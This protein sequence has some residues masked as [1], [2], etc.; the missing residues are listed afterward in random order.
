MPRQK[1][2]SGC[3]IA[4]TTPSDAVAVATSPVPS[5]PTDWWCRLLTRQLPAASTGDPRALVQARSGRN[6]HFVGESRSGG[7]EIACVRSD[8]DRRRYVLD[9]RSAGGDVEHLCAPADGQQRQV[10]RHRAPG[11][12]DLELVA[13]RFRVL[14]RRVPLLAVEH[15]IDVPAAG[16]HHAVEHADERPRA[17]ADFEHADLRA[18]LLDRR[19]VVVQFAAAGDADD[20]EGHSRCQGSAI[21][22][23]K[24]LLPGA[25][26]F[27]DPRSRIPT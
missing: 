19:D 11:E 20:W 1:R 8:V 6:A 13:P 15:R 4:S 24:T 17:L 26:V 23:P 3:S 22:D 12:I 14:D 7:V 25:R 9:E 5:R 16:Q 18:R 21:R 10:S 2:A 27:A